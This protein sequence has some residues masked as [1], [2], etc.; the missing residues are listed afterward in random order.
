M[1][2]W[3]RSRADQRIPTA[4]RLRGDAPVRDDRGIA[5]RQSVFVRIERFRV[6][7]AEAAREAQPRTNGPFRGDAPVR[8]DRG[9]AGRQ[10]VFARIASIAASSAP[11]T[12][13][14]SS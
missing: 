2:G 13:C 11:A 14:N 6:A 9:I 10:G 7:G 3:G 12:L 1:G 5:G 8:D 4:G